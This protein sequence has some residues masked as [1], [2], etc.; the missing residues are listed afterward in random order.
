[1]AEI[2]QEQ[3]NLFSEPEAVKIKPKS[4]I[5]NHITLHSIIS[6][7]NKVDCRGFPN[8][9]PYF[10]SCSNQVGWATPQRMLAVKTQ[11]VK[12]NELVK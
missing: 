1:M 6:G 8:P 11:K 2:F 7:P 3:A 10:S 9:Q 5:S 4:E 12:S